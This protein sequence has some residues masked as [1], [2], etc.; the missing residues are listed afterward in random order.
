MA[1]AT[2]YVVILTAEY[3]GLTTATPAVQLTG[4]NSFTIHQT[5]VASLRVGFA[6]FGTRA[7]S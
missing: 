4:A 1:S 7:E 3:T 6:V 2:D 5:E